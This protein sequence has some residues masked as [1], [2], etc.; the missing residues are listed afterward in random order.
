MIDSWS[1]TASFRQ[2]PRA[3]RGGAGALAG[4][5][6]PAR[7]LS[8]AV[9]SHWGRVR[10]LARHSDE[11]RAPAPQPSAW[12][13]HVFREAE[14]GASARTKGSAVQGCL[15]IL[16]TVQEGSVYE[17]APK[18]IIAFLTCRELPKAS[19]LDRSNT[20]VP[21]KICVNRR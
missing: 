13:V 17:L 10:K 11:G 12:F 1:K 7:A 21:R 9:K 8:P 20:T 4:A 3:K 15:V 2:T 19:P 6:A 14:A 16:K 5:R 18:E